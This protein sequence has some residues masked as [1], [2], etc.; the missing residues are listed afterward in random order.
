MTTKFYVTV[1]GAYLG[2]YDG[3]EPGEGAIEVAVPPDHALQMWDG[4]KWLAYVPAKEEQER[5][6]RAAYVAEADPL[7]FM[8]QRGEATEAEWLAKVVEIKAR[9]S[10]P[11]E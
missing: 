8:S 10:Y 3:A 2:G 7:F 1:T 4:E 11:V 9:Y 5:A 6:R